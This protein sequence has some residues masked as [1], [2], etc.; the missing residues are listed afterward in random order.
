MRI[1]DGS[2]HRHYTG[3]VVA[4]VT[5]LA[6]VREA[7]ADT[8]HPGDAFLLGS[9]DGCEPEETVAAFRGVTR[10][11]DVPVETLDAQYT[12]L[13]FLSDGGFRFFLPAWLVADLDGR[14]QTADPVFH[15]TSGFHRL[16]VA[17][18]VGRTSVIRRSG[19]DVLMNPRRLGA[20]TFED[21]AR[22]RLGVFCR[23]EAQALVGYL[24]HRREAA[25][26]KLERETIDAALER[27]WLARADTA[28]TREDL[29]AHL[30]D[31]DAFRRA[32]RSR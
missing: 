2:R 27:F 25:T 11:D 32:L 24:R 22:H 3:S 16:A 17:V 14:L 1:R 6:L 23:E 4:P 13:S 9:R 21:Q 31:E 26:L 15:L 20:L 28:P 7:F 5:L 10:W 29:A 12:A 18:P 8:P 19:G 30:A